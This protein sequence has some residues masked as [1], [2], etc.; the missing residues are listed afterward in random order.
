MINIFWQRAVWVLTITT[1]FV[2]ATWSMVPAQQKAKAPP[3]TKSVVVP[4]LTTGGMSLDELKAAR[5]ALEAS[6]DLV[7]S[8]ESVVPDVDLCGHVLRLG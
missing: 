3:T 1:M 4:P 8:V 2:V 6:Q 5:A 7:E